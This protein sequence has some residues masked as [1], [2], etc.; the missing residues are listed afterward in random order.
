MPYFYGHD[1]GDDDPNSSPWEDEANAE[2]F[3]RDMQKLALSCRKYYRETINLLDKLNDA[4]SFILYLLISGNRDERAI[5][6][7]SDLKRALD[8]FQLFTLGTP[9]SIRI[10]PGFQDIVDRALKLDCYDKKA[11]FE[12]GYSTSLTVLFNALSM[13]ERVLDTILA[14]ARSGEQNFLAR[15]EHKWF[16]MLFH[17]DK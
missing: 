8:F 7:K 11:W 1:N 6:V 16:R 12:R 14:C 9:C 17:V 15:Q 4:Q 2:D 3:R 5:E 13:C 10:D